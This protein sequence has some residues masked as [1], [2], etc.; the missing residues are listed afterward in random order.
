MN[1]TSN[2]KRESFMGEQAESNRLAA[3]AWR[4]KHPN[5]KGE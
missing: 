1:S 3:I 5:D 4:Q 2:I